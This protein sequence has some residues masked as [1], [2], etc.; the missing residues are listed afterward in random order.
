M[1]TGPKRQFSSSIPP[2]QI[3]V[4]LKVTCPRIKN[5]Q[6]HKMQ[7]FLLTV[8]NDIFV[9][10]CTCENNPYYTVLSSQLLLHVHVQSSYISALSL[11][12]LTASYY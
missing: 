11:S 10:I 1:L 5:S 4:V 9:K 12:K 6:I 8:E 2:Q 3:A 7:F